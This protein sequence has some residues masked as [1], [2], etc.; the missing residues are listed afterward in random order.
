MNTLNT[1]NNAL[2]ALTAQAN[3]IKDGRIT[4]VDDIIKLIIT[5]SKAIKSD[6]ENRKMAQK[7]IMF[8]L[9][10]D[11]NTKL[12]TYAK[13]TIKL[14]YKL[15]IDGYVINKEFLTLARAEKLCKCSKN[16]VN[17]LKSIDDTEEYNEL[18]IQLIS[19]YEI[20]KA[21]KAIS[22]MG[23]DYIE[24]AKL[25]R[26]KKDTQKFLNLLQKAI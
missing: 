22:A 7:W 26:A 1:L 19:D 8:T 10:E 20:E 23:E 5:E 11:D 18:V 13:R 25:I 6:F 17:K 14:T 4:L 12:D 2:I 3:T 24:L 9:L 21:K 15:L 16:E